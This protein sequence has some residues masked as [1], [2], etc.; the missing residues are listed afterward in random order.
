M[1]AGFQSVDGVEGEI[2]CCPGQGACLYLSIGLGTVVSEI[3]KKDG[4][5]RL[6]RR[7]RA[8]G[9]STLELEDSMLNVSRRCQWLFTER[10][11]VSHAY[12]DAQASVH[13]S[14]H[15]PSKNIGACSQIRLA[16][17]RL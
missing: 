13:S 8:K 6:T 10:H 4:K 17:R 15:V 5:V 16:A 7:A 2:D 11:L 1:E 3:E 12:N 14:L 9:L